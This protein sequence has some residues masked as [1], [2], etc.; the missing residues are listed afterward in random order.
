M[1][2]RVL[3]CQVQQTN[4]KGERGLGGSGNG[5]AIVSTLFFSVIL[6][7]VELLF[8]IIL[9]AGNDYSFRY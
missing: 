9:R 2:S 1:L 5:G 8:I 6:L 3:R 4:L 7:L